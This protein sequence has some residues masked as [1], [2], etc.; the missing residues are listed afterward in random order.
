MDLLVTRLIPYT[1]KL[2]KD[3]LFYLSVDKENSQDAVTIP[4]EIRR[5]K[6]TRILFVI[7]FILWNLFSFFAASFQ[8]RSP[9][10]FPIISVF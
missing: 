8:W 3:A 5:C 9:L 2:V 10:K 7:L 1:A 4:N 6:W